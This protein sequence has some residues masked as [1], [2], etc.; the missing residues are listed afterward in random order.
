MATLTVGAGKQYATIAAAVAAAMDGDTVAVSAGTYINDFATIKT[1]ITLTSV[2]G[3]VAMVSTA[4]PGAVHALLTVAT[5]ATVNGFVFSGMKAADGAGAGI[6]YQGGALVVTNSLFV[7]NQ[8]GLLATA[9]AAGTI[10]IQGSEFSGNGAGDGFSHNISVGAI[11]S[12]T[13]QSSYIH[14]AICGDEVRSLAAATTITGSRIEDNGAGSAYAVDA[15]NG[16]IVSLSGNT[17]Q[18]GV[19]STVAAMVRFGGGTLQGGSSASISGNTVVSD[20]AGAVLLQNLTSVIAGV[21]SNTV[22]GLAGI[23]TGP[24]AAFGNSVWTVRP[25]VS[26]ATLAAGPSA[27]VD[28]GRAGAVS[29]TGHVLTVG[30]GQAYATLA[31]AVAAAVDGDT[32]DVAGGLYVNDA[33]VITHRVII[34]GVGG[35]AQFTETTA[36]A[37]GLAQFVTTSDAT[38]RNIEIFGASLPGGLAAGIHA[39][40]GHL[41]IVNSTIHDNQAGIVADAGAAATVGIYDSEIAGNGTASGLGADIAVAGINT[42]TVVNSYIHDSVAGAEIVSAAANTVLTADRISQVDGAG[43]AAI[44]LPNAGQV[45]ISGSAIEKGASSQSAVLVQVGGAAAYAGSLVSLVGDTVISDLVSA[46]TVFVS[47]TSAATVTASG[48]TVVGGIAG[49]V[50]VSCGTSTGAVAKSALTI[51]TASPWGAITAPGAAALTVSTA[52][53]AGPAAAGQLVLRMSETAYQGDA[54]FTLKVDGVTVAGT[55]TATADHANGMSQIF[56]VAG[57]YA[58]GPHTVAVAFTNSLNGAAAGQ[59]RALH[60]DGMAF[61]GQEVGAP[62]AMTA[63]GATMLSTAPSASRV[64]VTV[65]L[66]E[67]AYKG[68]AMAFI[69]IDGKVQGGVQTVTASHALGQEQKMSFLLNLAPGAHTAAITYLNDLT[70]GPGQDRNLYVDSIDVAGVHYGVAAALTT[71]ATSSVAFTVAPPPAANGGLFVT[72]GAPTLLSNLVPTF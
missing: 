65:N 52:A 29:A 14:D 58:P 38:F 55:L 60:I 10:L 32:I 8:N 40:G 19:L 12:L 26:T 50:T 66:A 7:G 13:I 42:L 3:P 9:A 44:V 43:G 6:R 15:P 63:N 30:A 11:K 25:T 69:S 53:P 4:T 51:N 68:D 1:K 17:I 22:Y 36:P 37:N 61:N 21:S 18:K 56:T 67:D 71:N 70:V 64:A 24:V 39:Q 5:D 33:A 28:Y 47:N 16:G 34:E 45:T 35:L 54:Q 72:A 62:I 57:P 48:T 41:T 31:A 46:P 2:G 59:G 27:A 20:H 23:A 49:S